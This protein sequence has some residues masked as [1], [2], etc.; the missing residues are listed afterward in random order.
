MIALDGEHPLDGL[1]HTSSVLIRT[2]RKLDR[3]L[4][5]VEVSMDLNLDWR[6]I[7]PKLGGTAF[8][9]ANLPLRKWDMD[10]ARFLDVAVGT[11]SEGNLGNKD[12]VG[13]ESGQLLTHSRN[14]R[15]G[16]DLKAGSTAHLLGPSGRRHSLMATALF[17]EF[18]SNL[19]IIL[20]R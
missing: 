7:V 3:T 9:E 17:S 12:Y 13:Y 11:E 15:T 18:L 2:T 14:I 19:E 8:R 16:F 6:N 1:E 4:D 5:R 20:R 10:L